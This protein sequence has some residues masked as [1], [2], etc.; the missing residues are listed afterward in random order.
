MRYILEKDYYTTEIDFSNEIKI[1]VGSLSSNWFFSDMQK[2]RNQER[3]NFSNG[4][5]RSVFNIKMF[6][7]K[8]NI[9]SSN[10]WLDK[11]AVISNIG[12]I[13]FQNKARKDTPKLIPWGASFKI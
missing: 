12:I 13:I 7:Y 2:W 5:L 3:D 10:I 6:E 9:L 4:V 11:Y 8:E 1:R